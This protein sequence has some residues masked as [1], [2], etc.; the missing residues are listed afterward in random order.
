MSV[1]VA[2][3]LDGMDVLLKKM[4]PFITEANIHLFQNTEKLNEDL[5]EGR[6]A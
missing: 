6:E 2:F 3:D 5:K 4:V 1:L